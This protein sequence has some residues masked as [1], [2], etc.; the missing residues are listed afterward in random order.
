MTDAAT[1]LARLEAVV[2]RLEALGAGPALAV[3]FATIN[4]DGTPGNVAA[5][6]LIESAWGNATSDSFGK[7]KIPNVI[8]GNGNPLGLLRIETGQF[9]GTLDVNGNTLVT[10]AGPFSSVLT[11]VVAN[12]KFPPTHVPSGVS[13]TLT[14]FTLSCRH[15]DGS[16]AANEAA[17]VNWIVI[18]RR[19]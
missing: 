14:N 4:P 5:D 12:A 1:T 8:A 3:P 15:F 2:A 11:V 16:A 6:E 17:Q 10:L 7:I 13:I 18:G 9:G 19:T